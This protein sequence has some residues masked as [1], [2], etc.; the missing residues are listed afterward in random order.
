MKTRIAI[1]TALADGVKKMKVKIELEEH[2]HLDDADE[3]LEKALHRKADPSESY[4][5][6]SFNDFHD[7]MTAVH[8]NLLKR[9]SQDIQAEIER[10]ISSRHNQ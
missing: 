9:I 4:E 6:A 10:A 3:L 5:E 8:N 1:F 7:H 2:E